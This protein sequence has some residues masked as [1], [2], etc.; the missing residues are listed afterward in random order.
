ML[1]VNAL[2]IGESTRLVGFRSKSEDRSVST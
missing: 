2:G 1:W